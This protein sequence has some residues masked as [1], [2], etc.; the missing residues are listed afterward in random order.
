MIFIIL[1]VSVFCLFL[2]TFIRRPPRKFVTAKGP[3]LGAEGVFL[4]KPGFGVG[5]I[6][7]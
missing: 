3:V 7:F 2:N 5:E 6:S 4:G 1:I